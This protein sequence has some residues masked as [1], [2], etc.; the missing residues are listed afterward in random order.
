MLLF[1]V[2]SLY[3]NQL[4]ICIS[5]H[6]P[7]FFFLKMC[8]STK[9]QKKM[10]PSIHLSCNT[11]NHLRPYK[12]FSPHPQLPY[13]YHHA[14]LKVID[15]LIPSSTQPMRTSQHQLAA[16]FVP[17]FPLPFNESD[18]T[19]HH[20]NPPISI[21]PGS[22]TGPSP[23]IFGVRPASGRKNLSWLGSSC[24]SPLSV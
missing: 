19:H 6:A 3:S 8:S 1:F 22:R 18:P 21:P 12:F 4:D 14:W 11:T 23:T 9:S 13:L 20:N 2:C 16:C 7:G 15:S 5:K 10:Q 24:N 17:A